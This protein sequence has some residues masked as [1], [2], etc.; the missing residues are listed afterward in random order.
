MLKLNIRLEG[1]LAA[2]AFLS[3]ARVNC[4]TDVELDWYS[5]QHKIADCE[6]DAEIQLYSRLLLWNFSYFPKG[7]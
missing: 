1:H 4:G 5:I 7:P 2:F 6:V 3:S